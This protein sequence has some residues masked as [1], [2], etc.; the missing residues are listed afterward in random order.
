MVAILYV[1]N[2]P[3]FKNDYDTKLWSRE[4]TE[5]LWYQLKGGIGYTLM[6]AQGWWAF[7]VVTLMATYLGHV[8]Q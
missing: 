4:S 6:M 2:T 1:K 3:E 8:T 5:N 7:D